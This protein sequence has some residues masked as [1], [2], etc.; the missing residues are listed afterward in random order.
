MR[1]DPEQ[2]AVDWDGLWTLLLSIL[3]IIATAAI[4]LFLTYLHVLRTARS[5]PES[6]NGCSG[7]FVFGKK[8]VDGAVD[9][10]YQLRLERALRLIQQQPECLVL[11]LGGTTSAGEPSEAESGLLYLQ[12]RGLPGQHNIRLEEQSKNTLD[13]LRNARQI[14]QQEQLN[15]VALISNRY[16]L[17]RCRL[18]ANSL[19]IRHTLCAAEPALNC[20]PEMLLKLFIEAAYIH[21]FVV[22]KTWARLTGNGRMLARVT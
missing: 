8:L 14:L 11:L 16:H 3:I 17:A 12:Q 7:C 20:N 15:Q 1:F 21:W 2:G 4:P 13:N 19:K 9:K 6:A 22:G 18:I 10:E 5:S